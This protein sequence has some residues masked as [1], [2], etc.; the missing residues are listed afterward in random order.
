METY[1]DYLRAYSQELGSRIVEMYPPLQGPKDPVAPELKTLLRKP[2]PVQAMTITGAAKYLQVEDSVRL[3]GECGTGKTLMS[4]GIAHAHAASKP[5]TALVMC[6]PHLVLKW[7]REVLITVPRARAFVVYDLRNGGDPS[8]PHGVVEVSMRNGHVVSKGLKTSVVELRKMGRKGWEQRCSVPAYFITSKES[9]KLSYFWKHAYVTPKSGNS[10]DCITNPETGKTVPKDEGGHLLRGDFDDVKHFEVIQR[11]GG[12][13]ESYSPLWEADRNK[14]QR[15]APLEY[16]GRYMKR[17]FTYAFAD[18]MHQLANDTAQG[19]NLAVLRRCSRKLIGNTGTLMGGYASDLFHIFFRM[20]PWKM[21]EDGYEAGTQGQA[22]FQATYGVLESIERVPDED[23]ACTRAAKS[24]FRLAKKPGA[25]PLLFG[26]FLMSSTVFVSLEDIAEFLPP[27]EE[28]VCEVELD[29]ELRQAY[30]KIQEDIQQA[31]RENRGNRSLMSLMLHRLMLY[32]DHPFGIGEIMGRKFDPQEKRLVPFL[33]TT[34]PDLPKD[35]LYPKEQR[36]VEDVR[37]E[38]RQGRR[39]QVFATFTGEYDVPE[40]LEG[41][42]RQAGFRVAVLRS[43]VP[44]L[45][46]EQWYAQRVKE[47]VEVIIGHPK[48]VETGLDL[49]WFPTIIFYQTGYSLHTLRQASRRSWRIG[50]RLA[51]RVK[52]MIYDGTTQRTCLRLMGRKMLVAL[53]ME[54]KFSGEGLHSM[55]AD[56][57]MLAAMARELVEKGGVGESAD[58]VWEEL[59][60]E[61]TGHLPTA[62]V[63]EPVLTMEPESEIPDM[64][65]GIGNSTPA[66]WGGPVLMHS[67]PKK[68]QTLWPTG[69][70]IGEQLGLF[71]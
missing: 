59:R 28:I 18:E 38:L 39:C 64:F 24:T 17:F 26:K 41:I 51:V 50:Q 27:Y 53:M 12:G 19:N 7:A 21:V 31:L 35:Q 44:A 54:G 63:I 13:T 66:P 52:F 60:K 32:P 40:R 25:S 4:I 48:L 58:A 30:E 34:A 42:L 62:T 67:Q 23:K 9:G 65:A 61:R 45:K 11:Q 1:H 22:D 8:K 29:G 33:V 47:G 46:R 15:M 2:L 57:D 68:K 5:Y 69:Y 36:L 16:M 20:E 6:P 14:I 37:E 56:D 70:V 49:L 3:V 43:S 10:R 71:G 55:D